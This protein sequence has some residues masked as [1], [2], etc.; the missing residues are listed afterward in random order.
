MPYL[1]TAALL[2]LLVAGCFATVGVAGY[3]VVKLVVG[4]M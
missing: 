4:A 3:E 1:V 2:V